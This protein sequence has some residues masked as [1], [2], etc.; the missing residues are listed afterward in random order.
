VD[1]GSNSRL[2]NHIK[3]FDQQDS[4]KNDDHKPT[5]EQ[6]S[7]L[8]FMGYRDIKFLQHPPYPSRMG[9]GGG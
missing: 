8:C 6:V 2:S 1:A 3:L 7:Q 9:Y 5:D 4:L